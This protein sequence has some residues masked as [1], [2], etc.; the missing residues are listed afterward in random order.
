MES[1]WNRSMESTWNPYG[2][3]PWNACWTVLSKHGFHHHSMAIPWPFHMES[4]VTM[5][6]KNSWDL[7]QNHSI[8]NPWN[9]GVE[10]I[11]INPRSVKTSEK[12]SLSNLGLCIQLGH[13]G[14]TCPCPLPWASL[15]TVFDVSGVHQVNI[16][17]CGCHPENPLD[18]HVQLL[19]KR[20]F[21]EWYLPLLW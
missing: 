15:F 19:R 1:I 20:W 10:S 17:Y 7:T 13:D 9:G 2:I 4:K 11:W 16:N 14:N 3:S 21:L 5:D 18:Q 6:P 8:W 12:M